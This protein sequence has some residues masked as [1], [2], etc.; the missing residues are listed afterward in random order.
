[1][2]HI[3][4]DKFSAKIEAALVAGQKYSIPNVDEAGL[5]LEV[6]VCSTVTSIPDYAV[7]SHRFHRFF[8]LEYPLNNYYFVT[9]SAN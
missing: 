9:A 2:C 1:M 7:S 6:L 4:S 3:V 8:C 5:T